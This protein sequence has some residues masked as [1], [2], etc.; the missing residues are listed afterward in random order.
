MHHLT[1]HIT[2]ALKKKRDIRKIGIISR[3]EHHNRLVL[4]LGRAPS[5]NLESWDSEGNL[6]MR[7]WGQGRS[8]EI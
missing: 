2:C 4:R 6:D 8:Y 5:L 7:F 1:H 3:Y